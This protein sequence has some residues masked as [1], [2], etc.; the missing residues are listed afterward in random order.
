MSRHWLVC[1]C[2][3][4]AIAAGIVQGIV[5]AMTATAVFFGWR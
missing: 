2:V 5:P 3:F 4:I 1:I